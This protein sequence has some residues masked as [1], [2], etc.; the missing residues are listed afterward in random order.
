MQQVPI[1]DKAYEL[2][3]TT[4]VADGA[5]M[6]MP[7]GLDADTKLVVLDLMRLAYYMRRGIRLERL[8]TTILILPL[9]LGTVMVAE[10]MINYFGPNG[11]FNR[12][13]QSLHL[14]SSPILLLQQNAAVEIALFIQGFP[15]VFL[16]VLGSMSAINPDLE[17]ASRMAGANEWQTFWRIIFPLTLPCIAIAFC[18][19]FVANFGVFPTA[20]L[21]GEPTH[22][23]HVL[24]VAAYNSAFTDFNQPLG[25]AIALIM[26]VLQLFVIGIVLFFQSRLARGA[27]ISGGKGA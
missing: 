25:T 26:G 16:L 10:G 12:T 4:F 6:I 17:K 11:W 23:T 3:G 7:K 9:T 27:S 1:G 15:F 5:F 20:N 22:E 8:I 14:I 18:L 19:N 21:V 13:L 24:A 2:Q